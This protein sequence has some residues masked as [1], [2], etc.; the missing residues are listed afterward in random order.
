MEIIFL[1]DKFCSDCDC[2]FCSCK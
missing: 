1:T 2:L